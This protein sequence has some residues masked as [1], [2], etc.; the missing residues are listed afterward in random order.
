MFARL[1]S[2]A[3]LAGFLAAVIT[4]VLQFTLTSALILKAET[5]EGKAADTQR[6]AGSTWIVPAHALLVHDH[7]TDGSSSHDDAEEWQPGEGLPRMAFT[8][9]AALI[10][11]VGCAFLLGAV[12]LALKYEPTPERGLALGIAGF[13]TAALAPSIGLPPELPGMGGAPLGARQAWWIL[14]VL[15]TGL[16]LHLIL[17][18]RVP[19][20]ILAGLVLIAAPHLVGAPHG[21]PSESKVPAELAAQFAARSLGISFVF[22]VVI[23]LSYGWV[24]SR[25]SQDGQ[26]QNIRG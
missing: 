7:G 16:G 14:T 6:P 4:T 10:G 2:A 12:M 24:W 3:L 15:A 25:L 26:S 13:A 8:G 9:L 1:A 18:R 23:G 19:L 22:W 20:A 21:A 11:G 5:F 17:M